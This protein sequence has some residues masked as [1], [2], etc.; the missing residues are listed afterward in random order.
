M[1]P[2]LFYFLCITITISCQVKP[3][4]ISPTA[5]TTCQDFRTGTF[6]L[7]HKL[8]GMTTTIIRNDSMH[9]EETNLGETSFK[10]TYKIKWL[11]DC[12]YEL[13]PS[14]SIQN[15]VDMSDERAVIKMNKI[16]KNTIFYKVYRN[17]NRLRS[18]S[19]KMIKIE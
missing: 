15:D 4:T 9:I 19:N 5:A 3:K 14:P 10:F 16:E 13:T 12:M 8:F 1:K 6:K 2:F 18:R 17:G 7:N 11:N